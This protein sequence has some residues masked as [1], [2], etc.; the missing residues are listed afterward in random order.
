MQQ[1]VDGRHATERPAV[2]SWP[3]YV[4]IV[5]AW[6]ASLVAVAVFVRHRRPAGQATLPTPRALLQMHLVLN[7]L[8]RF[9]LTPGADDRLFDG[10][11]RMADYLR[12]AS[13][14][15]AANGSIGAEPM[16]LFLESFLALNQWL[17]SEPPIPVDL[18]VP[19]N[20]LRG[21]VC[22]LASSLQR[23]TGRLDG[24]SPAGL[25]I[26]MLPGTSPKSLQCELL[27]T[28]AAVDGIPAGTLHPHSE[29]SPLP[30]GNGAT[31]RLAVDGVH[32]DAPG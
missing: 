25:R 13:T 26:R 15:Q 23:S 14:V 16:R 30:D 9:A 5:A 11:E 31:A 17:R 7:V 19:G 1:A 4:S 6:A 3:F 12:A 32:C 18:Q 20:M 10:V 28:G 8:N 21:D 29:W 2:D 27:A 22:A 24:W